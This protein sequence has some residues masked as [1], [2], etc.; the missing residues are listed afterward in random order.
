MNETFLAAKRDR[1][2][3][4]VNENLDEYNVFFK[5]SFIFSIHSEFS[6][7][8]APVVSEHNCGICCL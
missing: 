2:E 4:E 5:S 8:V 6:D 7:S 3:L 1:K